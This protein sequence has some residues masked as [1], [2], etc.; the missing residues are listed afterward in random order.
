MK[1]AR[2]SMAEKRCRGFWLI[3]AGALLLVAAACGSTVGGGRGPDG[4]GTGGQ[5]GA[6]GGAGATDADT[7]GTICGGIAGA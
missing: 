5:G 3:R 2:R 4:G 7:G 1:T 6:K